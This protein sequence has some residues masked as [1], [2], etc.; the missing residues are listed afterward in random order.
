MKNKWSES[1]PTMVESFFKEATEQDIAK[2]LTEIDYDFYKT[3]KTPVL[4]F[5]ENNFFGNDTFILDIDQSLAGRPVPSFGKIKIQQWTL[6]SPTA[7]DDEVN[8]L[9]AA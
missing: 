2:L 3:V 5:I 6:F 7:A 9:M 4:D 1:V 8:Y